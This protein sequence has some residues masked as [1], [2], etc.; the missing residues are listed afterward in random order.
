MKLF[1]EAV[2]IPLLTSQLTEKWQ[3]FSR[4]V[5]EHAK[6]NNT[7]NKFMRTSPRVHINKS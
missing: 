7:N 1:N 3:M 5:A 6:Q 2:N 4:F